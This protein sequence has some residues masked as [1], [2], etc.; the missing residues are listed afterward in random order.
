M[1]GFLVSPSA[2]SVH[3]G[4]SFGASLSWPVTLV[5]RWTSARLIFAQGRC[6]WASWTRTARDCDMTTTARTRWDGRKR[7]SRRPAGHIYSFCQIW[8][9]VF[10]LC[11]LSAVL[12]TWHEVLKV[13]RKFI[14]VPRMLNQGSKSFNTHVLM[15]NF[16]FFLV[17]LH[18]AI[19]TPVFIF[20]RA[21]LTWTHHCQSGRPPPSSSSLLPRLPIIPA[22][23]W[24]R[25]LRKLL[26][27]P[28][29]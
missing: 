20:V 8:S 15:R 12:K 26:I 28:D 21:N 27:N 11:A 9:S 22:T 2:P 5:T 1:W 3:L 19:L 24:R 29:K 13:N 17:F 25:I 18:G 10:F 7:Y 14:L 16:Y 6:W 4:R 23:K